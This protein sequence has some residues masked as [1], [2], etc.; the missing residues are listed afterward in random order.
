MNDAAHAGLECLGDI[1]VY[2]DRDLEYVPYDPLNPVYVAEPYVP[3]I[4][5]SKTKPKTKPKSRAR[6]KSKAKTK[7]NAPFESVQ[8]IRI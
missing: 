7:A 5:K 3:N 6:S 4:P 1:H 2:P 8:G